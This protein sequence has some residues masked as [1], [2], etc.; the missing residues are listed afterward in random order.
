LIALIVL[1]VIKLHV[2]YFLQ[3]WIIIRPISGGLDT[4]AFIVQRWRL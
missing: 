3:F 1:V 2:Y 4:F